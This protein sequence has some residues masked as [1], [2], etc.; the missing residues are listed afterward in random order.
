[1]A[2]TDQRPGRC[3]P[4]PSSDE[5]GAI[6]VGVPL[7]AAEKLGQDVR[8]HIRTRAWPESLKI[9]TPPNRE[10]RGRNADP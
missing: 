10:H 4:A 8:W 1:M 7:D 9:K 6:L 3:R 5:A 2:V